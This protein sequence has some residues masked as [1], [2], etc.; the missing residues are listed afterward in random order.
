VTDSA[1][2][3]SVDTVVLYNELAYHDVLPVQWRAR[4]YP[5]NRFELAGLQ[6]SNLLLLQACAALEEQPIRDHSEDAGP[7]A[8]ELARLDFKLNL[9]LQLLGRLVLKERMPPSTTIH[10]NAQGAS[11]TAVGEPPAAGERGVLRVHLHSSLPQPLELMGVVSGV[12]GALVK[13]RFE[14]LGDP[15]AELIQR[16]AFLRHRQDVADARKSRNSATPP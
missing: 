9:V 11:W 15:V 5:L 10:F 7:L 3:V 6:E 16:L 4:E 8:G 13:V 1:D 2:T 14:E 12:E